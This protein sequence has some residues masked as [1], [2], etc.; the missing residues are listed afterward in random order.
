MV[1]I[2]GGRCMCGSRR[3]CVA[4]GVVNVGECWIGCACDKVCVFRVLSV[5][6]P[7]GL[8][9]WCCG[10]ELPLSLRLDGC[11]SGWEV[12]VW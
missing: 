11:D 7:S 12:Y 9:R 10:D 1:V 4:N 3:A 5:C 8:L 2:A 6:F